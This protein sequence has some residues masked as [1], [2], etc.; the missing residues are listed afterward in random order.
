MATQTLATSRRKAFPTLDHV[1]IFA[2]LALIAMR[3]LVL[4]IQPHDFWWHMATGRVIIETGSIPII[5][6]FSYTQAGETFINQ[7]WLAQVLMYGLYQ[8]GGVPLIL[9]VQSGII[10]LAYG[11]LLRL[12][13]E[14]S[15]A[16]RMS[17]L[18]L[19]LT[20]P[21]SF[22]N[23]NVRPQ[24]YT[25][26]LFVAF[27]VLL[28]H[29]RERARG[30]VEPPADT[31]LPPLLQGRLWLLPLLMVLWVNLHGTFVLGGMLVALTFGGLLL[32][33]W[34]GNRR[35]PP[36]EVT[37]AR[38]APLWHLFFWGAITALALLVNPRGVG[39]L[40]YVFGLLNTS[41]VTT[42]VAEWSP[43]TTRTGTGILFFSFYHCA[44]WHPDLQPPPPRPAGYAAGT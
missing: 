2:A 4:P 18:V 31:K 29:W 3:P 37:R 1:W 34:L 8:L 41:A 19:L 7:A 38:R 36:D 17:V 39:V 28:T 27:L 40:G 25:L 43:T 32:E 24:T 5:D 13:I 21:L 35:T 15:G 42:L 11:M 16:V 23:W 12:C 20:L 10:V 22:D 14:R 6:S 30:T 26:P 44:S 9:L 33:R